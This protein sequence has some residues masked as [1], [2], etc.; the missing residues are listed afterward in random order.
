MCGAHLEKLRLKP[1]YLDYV[2]TSVGDAAS[3]P[4]PGRL[5]V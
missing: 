5:I 4:K 1:D 3:F 2:A